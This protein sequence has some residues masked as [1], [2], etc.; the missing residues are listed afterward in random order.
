M[1]LRQ[2][3]YFVAVAEEGNFTR[4]AERVHISQSGISAQI[5]QLE[6]DLGAILFDRSSRI[7]TLT[8]AGRAALEHARAALT[9]ADAV[10]Q[11]VDEVNELIR[12][13]LVVGMVTACAATPLFDAL[14]EFHLAHPGVE[15]ALIEGHTDLL[16]ER[17]RAG[18]LDIALVGTATAPPAGLETLP[19][20]SEGL[21]AAV[22]PE[23]PLSSRRRVTLAE[24]GR[25]P[26][27]CL[28]EGTGIRTALDLDF[29]ARGIRPN[30]ALQASDPDAVADL[31]VRG[32]GVAIL[33]ES[34]V[35]PH[36]DRLRKLRIADATTPA[37]L[38]L[39]WSTD[40]NP[41]LREFVRYSRKVFA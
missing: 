19:I 12:G 26:I 15:V 2:L 24:I 33:S 25:H 32:L 3:E 30:I 16:V 40:A 23:H 34:M 36:D 9:S 38:A 17:V 5:R 41:A 22:P 35:T 20:L 10:R 4:A 1:D 21:V 18:S 27:L 28:P 6:H 39:V 7:A 14:S 37:V 11:A 31:A 13:R 29:A 8:T